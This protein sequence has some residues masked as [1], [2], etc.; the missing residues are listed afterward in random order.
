MTLFAIYSDTINKRFYDARNDILKIEDHYYNTSLGYRF[1]WL[2][3]GINNLREKPIFGHGIGSYKNTIKIYIDKNNIHHDDL[4]AI[5]NNPH[6]ICKY[7]ISIGH[8]WIIYIFSF[9]T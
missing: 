2:Q 9:S 8:I 4:N 1:L 5:G 3:N 7:I 6:E